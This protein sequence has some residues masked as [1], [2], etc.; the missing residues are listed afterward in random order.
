VGHAGGA[1][2]AGNVIILVHGM[3]GAFTGDSPICIR[4]AEVI[5]EIG[6]V[7]AVDQ[8]KRDHKGRA[9][10]LT[11]EGAVHDFFYLCKGAYL[12]VSNILGGE[13][14]AESPYGP[15]EAILLNIDASSEKFG[16]AGNDE[17]GYLRL[18]RQDHIGVG[19]QTGVL[20]G[21]GK[22]RIFE[23]L[24]KLWIVFTGEE[25]PGDFR[26]ADKGGIEGIDPEGDFT[27]DFGPLFH[28][29]PVAETEHFGFMAVGND[30]ATG[31]AN[32]DSS[33][34][35]VRVTDCVV[36]GEL[37]LFP[38]EGDKLAAMGTGDEEVFDDIGA[39]ERSPD[40]TC[41]NSGG[42]NDADFAA[43]VFAI[44]FRAFPCEGDGV[45]L[46][47]G[48]AG[49]FIYFVKEEETYGEGGE[50]GGA[51][52]AGDGDTHVVETEFGLGGFMG[53]E[54]GPEGFRGEDHRPDT[55]CDNTFP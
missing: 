34:R 38:V 33:L 15:I 17:L 37:N 28:G 48:R 52:R 44:G 6:V 25:F 45:R 7:A 31:W 19:F 4:G 35:T 26:E 40:M 47:F 54:F 42:T 36:I 41:A 12:P 10:T 23:I 21:Q 24:V 30:S 27:R 20:P 13:K 46:L 50:V 29:T 8:G 5:D 18:A 22:P 2:N 51:V 39:F 49:E 55:L 14:V 11:S 3:G 16:P 32:E 9:A 1:V 53:P 43:S